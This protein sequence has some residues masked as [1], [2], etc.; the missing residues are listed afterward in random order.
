M[1]KSDCQKTIIKVIYVVIIKVILMFFFLIKMMVDGVMTIII[2]MGLLTG[3]HYL[4][5]LKKINY[6]TK[7]CL[8]N[9]YHV[10]LLA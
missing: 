7:I 10:I 1:L 4:N 6:L 9:I 2:I 3:C 8:T 5:Y